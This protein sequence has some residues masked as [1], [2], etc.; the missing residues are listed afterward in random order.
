MRIKKA[1]TKREKLHSANRDAANQNLSLSLS[2][3]TLRTKKSSKIESLR[4]IQACNK[5][6]QEERRQKQSATKQTKPQKR[7]ERK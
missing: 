4:E 1:Q 3:V 7:H 5:T 2:H 6:G